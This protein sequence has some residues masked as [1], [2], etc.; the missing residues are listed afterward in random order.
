VSSGQDA[1]GEV[2]VEVEVGGLTY[3]GTGVSTDIIEASAR[4]YL[5]ALNKTLAH[6]GGRPMHPQHGV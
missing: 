5:Q 2:S 3:H 1:Q 6:A 4:A